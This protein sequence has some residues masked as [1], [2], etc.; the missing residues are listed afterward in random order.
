MESLPQ[1]KICDRTDQLGVQK[2]DIVL[3]YANE[4]VLSWKDLR[5]LTSKG[6]Y[7]EY[8][9][10]NILRNQQL[11]NILVPRGPLGVRLGTTVLD[12][13]LEYNY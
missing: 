4:K 6:V 7:G 1:D 11:I 8:V 3:I 5:E 2:S 13:E 10:L 9:N 12:P